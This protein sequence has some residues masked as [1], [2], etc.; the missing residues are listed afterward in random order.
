MVHQ[1]TYSPDI[2]RYRQKTDAI[3]AID[4]GEKFTYAYEG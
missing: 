3:D 1:A 2:R 4:G